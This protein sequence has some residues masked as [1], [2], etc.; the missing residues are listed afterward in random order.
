M[1]M[2]PFDKTEPPATPMPGSNVQPSAYPPPPNAYQAPVAPPAP[3][4]YQAAPPPMPAPAYNAQASAQAYGWRL[5]K[6]KSTA[7]L[8]AIF[9]GFVVWAYT[10]ERDAWKFWT[11]FGISIADAILSGITLGIWLFVAIPVGIGIYIW[12]I[13]DA[14]ARS[15]QFYDVYPAA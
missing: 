1:S 12:G 7:V 14:V 8:L 3:Y 2:D 11:A 10:Y 6:S 9:A 13:V 4:Q 15:Q 5:P